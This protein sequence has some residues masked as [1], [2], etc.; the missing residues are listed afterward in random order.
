MIVV[1][2]HPNLLP[3]CSS[4]WINTCL[5]CD[6]LILVKGATVSLKDVYE[7]LPTQTFIIIKCHHHHVCLLCGWLNWAR[8][9]QG[10]WKTLVVFA[11]PN[12]L[13]SFCRLLSR[14]RLCDW[15]NVRQGCHSFLG[16]RVWVFAY[17]NFIIKCHHHHVC[18]LCSWLKLGKGATRSLKDVCFCLPKFSFFFFSLS[19]SFSLSVV[20]GKT[21]GKDATVSLKD[22]QVSLPT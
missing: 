17:P 6:W 20:T 14:C 4:G 21:L 5:L 1:F 12:F 22:V 2:A 18:L 13:S 15:Q 3:A 11:Y 19:S 10:P 9:P 7:S 8:V 16:R